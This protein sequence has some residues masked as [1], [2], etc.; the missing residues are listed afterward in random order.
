MDYLYRKDGT[1]IG[2]VKDDRIFDMN[3]R[4]IGQLDGSHVH[5]M[6]GGYVGEFDN[7]MVLDKYKIQG[8]MAP[9]APRISSPAAPTIQ[10]LPGISIYDDASDDLFDF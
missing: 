4:S 5:N 3:G 10:R 7:G 6:S 2:V 9:G 8:P 1:P